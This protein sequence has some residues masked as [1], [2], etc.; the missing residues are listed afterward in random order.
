MFDGTSDSD[1]ASMWQRAKLSEL[2]L[3]RERREIEDEIIK[4]ASMPEDYTGTLSAYDLKIT[5]SQSTNVDGEALKELA[6]EHAMFDRLGT[7]FRWKP[8]ICR[9]AWSAAT[10]EERAK[11]SGAITTKAARPSFEMKKE[12]K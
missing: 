4:R 7:L 12:N 2:E 9:K 5:Y 6:W 10:D 11:L 1:L 3:Q 8:E